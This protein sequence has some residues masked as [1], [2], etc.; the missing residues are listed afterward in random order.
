ME[1]I[2]TNIQPLTIAYLTC[3][4]EPKIEWFFY[5]LK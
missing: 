2:N 3:R 4:K 1:N 5:S